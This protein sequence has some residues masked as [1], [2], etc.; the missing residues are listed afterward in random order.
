MGTVP[1][2]PGKKGILR[3]LDLISYLP[4]ENR[5]FSPISKDI[6]CIAKAEL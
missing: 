3:G 1:N 5:D 2:R 4:M 6:I